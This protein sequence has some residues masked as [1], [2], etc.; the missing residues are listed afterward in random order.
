MNKGELQECF[1]IP[2]ILTVMKI[3]INVEDVVELLSEFVN[4]KH[5]IIDVA[6]SLSLVSGQRRLQV[7]NYTYHPTAALPQLN[8]NVSVTTVCLTHYVIP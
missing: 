7:R 2:I 8:V 6:E 1:H 5:Y 3:K 4:S